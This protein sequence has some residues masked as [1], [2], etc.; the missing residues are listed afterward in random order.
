MYFLVLGDEQQTGSVHVQ[1]MYNEWTGSIRVS[2]GDDTRN[3]N[4]F[5]F[6]GYREHAGGLVY[7]QQVFV[8]VYR[9]QLV[10][11]RLASK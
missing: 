6:P 8:F 4:L 5:R 3:G 10:G 7:D 9:F 2:F 11:F 1:P